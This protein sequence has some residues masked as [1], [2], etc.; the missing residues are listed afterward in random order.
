MT[1]QAR[2]GRERTVKKKVRFS[3][4]VNVHGIEGRP[5]TPRRTVKRPTTLYGVPLVYSFPTDL[6]MSTY[7]KLNT[8]FESLH[9]TD[10]AQ[11]NWNVLRTV[12]LVVK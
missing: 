8:V 5:L 9:G 1:K 11:I 7:L 3:K 10:S 4:E 2:R 6:D 12:A